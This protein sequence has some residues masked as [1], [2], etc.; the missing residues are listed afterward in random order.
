MTVAPNLKIGFFAQHQLDDLIP[1]QSAVEHVRRLM[2]AEPEAKVRARVAQMG[3]ATQKMDTAAKD[4]SGGEKARLLMGLAAFEAPNLLILDE[5]TNHLDIDSRR[6]LIDALNSYSGAV[7]LISHDRYLIE[8]TVDRLWL[9]R[10]GTVKAYDGDLDEYRDLIVGSS[11]KPKKDRTEPA[12]VIEEAAKPAAARKLNPIA[13]KKKIDELSDL[14][15][16]IERLIQG[17][18]TELSDPAIY[19]KNPNRAADLTKARANAADKLAR[20]EEEWLELSTEY[21]DALSG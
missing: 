8:A 4:L 6:A 16:K 18:D 3:L 12:P 2:P 1:E 7:I 17:I 21:E 13:V 19:A 5:P 14:M 11:R 15:A 10:D 20:T 9:V